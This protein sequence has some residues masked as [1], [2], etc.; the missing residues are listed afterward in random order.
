MNKKEHFG[1]S[2]DDSDLL[3]VIQHQFELAE[4]ICGQ[5]PEI[6]RNFN[7]PVFADT[8]DFE[9]LVRH[10]IELYNLKVQEK[11]KK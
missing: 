6:Y 5:E 10:R 7:I 8:A 9:N 11:S 2:N 3:S 1:L 4:T